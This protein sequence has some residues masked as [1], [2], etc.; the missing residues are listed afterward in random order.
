MDAWW[1][2]LIRAVFDP[3]LGDAARIPLTF[4]NAPSSGGSA[5]EDGFYGSPLDR[6]LDGARATG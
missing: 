6:P 4:D 1:E 5:Y 2:P 3:V